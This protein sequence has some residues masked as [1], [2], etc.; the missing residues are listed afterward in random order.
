VIDTII[1]KIINE[2]KNS[3]FIKILNSL[4]PAP[5]VLWPPAMHSRQSTIRQPDEG[6]VYNYLAIIS[7]LIK[8]TLQQ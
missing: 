7:K 5:L 1:I 3:L 2:I 8:N 6:R 4:L